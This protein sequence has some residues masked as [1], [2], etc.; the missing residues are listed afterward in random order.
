MMDSE[1]GRRARRS[2]S[3]KSGLVL[4]LVGA[5][6]V[7]ALPPLHIFPAFLAFA[8]VA[9][10]FHRAPNARAA[11]GVLWLFAFG[12][13]LAGLYWVGIAFFADAERFGVLAAPGVLAL[14]AILSTITAVIIA[15]FS[16]LARRHPLAAIL[17]IASLWP[18]TD[19]LRGALGTQFPWNPPAI[20]L[21][22]SD[23][24]YQAL[25]WIGVPGTSFL[26]L[27]C[28]MSIGW[29][30]FSRN[31]AVFA[32][33][34]VIPAMLFAAGNQRLDSLQMDAA[35][36]VSL[37]IVQPAIAQHHKWDPE[38]RRE[39]F[40]RHIELSLL[41]GEHD[42]LI[43]PESSVPYRLDADPTARE[44]VAGAIGG[45]DGRGGV[46]ALVGSDHIDFDVEPRILNN[47]VYAISREGE[48]RDRYDKVDLVPF[49]EFLPFRSIL[50]RIGLDALAVGSIDFQPGAGRRTL[51]VASVPPF[52]PLVCFEAVFPG[53]ATDGSGRAR[54][55]LNVTNDAWFGISSGPY[56]H[57]A[58]ARMRAVETGLPL[59][60]AAN[61]GISVV[62]DAYGR[63][64]DHLQ[65]G[66]IGVLD[67]E[68][69]PALTQ[70]P[71]VSRWPWL[72]WLLPALGFLAAL[73]L[74]SRHGQRDADA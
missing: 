11:F 59:V 3:W 68:L 50:G 30:A 54:W 72:A 71:P 25:A 45:G 48:V 65:L 70:P 56:Q 55:L 26:V 57:L 66:T 20:I 37:R 18:V 34:I 6:S 16:P 22:A 13:F 15:P 5:L 38:R 35:S 58:M 19:L 9:V 40:E 62:T 67:A 27:L 17:L 2:G 43:W 51:E 60:R 7:L 69:P 64:L 23:S 29:G 47:S 44:M 4:M 39:W 63:I 49:G 32:A 8:W 73:A 31:A 46:A 53:E 61:T 52:S 14:A 10:R 74:A 33:G 1:A 36:G 12:Y 42:V 41:P 28:F 21:A 24:L